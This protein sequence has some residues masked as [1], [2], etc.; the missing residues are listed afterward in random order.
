MDAIH[1]WATRV[2]HVTMIDNNDMDPE[3][4]IPAPEKHLD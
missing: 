1:A 3:L 2:M 4:T